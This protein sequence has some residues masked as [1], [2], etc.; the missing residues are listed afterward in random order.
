VILTR[1]TNPDLKWRN[2]IWTLDSRLPDIARL[3]EHLRDILDRFENRAAEIASI[4]AQNWRAEF[5]C[6]LLL[7]ARNEGTTVAAETIM[8]MAAPRRSPNAGERSSVT[9][10][11]SGKWV[12]SALC[13]SPTNQCCLPAPRTRALVARGAKAER[14]RAASGKESLPLEGSLPVEKSQDR[15]C[16]AWGIGTAYRAALASGIS[17]FHMQA[18]TVQQSF[19]LGFAMLTKWKHA[20]PA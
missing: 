13:S 2:S 4:R 6:G 18:G 15:C 11:R 1:R 12:Q 19:G 8:R 20:T 9:D 10:I 14:H 5:R 17:S 3:D 16:P 7:E